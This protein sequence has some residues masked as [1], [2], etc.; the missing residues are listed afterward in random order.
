LAAADREQAPLRPMDLV[1]PMS[2]SLPR[3]ELPPRAQ[4]AKVARQFVAEVLGGWGCGALTEVAQLL[5]SEL[6]TNALLHAGTVIE[7]D[8][9]MRE[10]AVRIGV[11]D[12][13]EASG[14][15]RGFATDATTGRGLVIVESLADDWGVSRTGEGKC[16]WFDLRLPMVD[17]S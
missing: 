4:S 9:R 8:C 13:V 3:I 16:T 17:G 7:V 1:G 10:D 15:R 12:R 6:V 5:V 14:A 2:I 11:S